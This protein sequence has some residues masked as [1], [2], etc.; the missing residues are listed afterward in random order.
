MKKIAIDIVKIIV[1]STIIA[2]VSCFVIT[3]KAQG[4]NTYMGHS[5]TPKSKEENKRALLR[6]W[7]GFSDCESKKIIDTV[8]FDK[9]YEMLFAGQI[10]VQYHMY[11]STAAGGIVKFKIRI[12][13]TDN[14]VEYRFYDM[15]HK[16]TPG[17]KHK[18]GGP[19]L[20]E[21]PLKGS[22]I[23]GKTWTAYQEQTMAFIHSAENE[24][25]RVVK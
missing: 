11:G 21:K 22:M 9:S 25:V 5:A 3:A 17:V 7:N 2:S 20:E 14:S 15:D 6:W 18:D 13:I 1:V 24:I 16:S 23:F 19:V 8:K 12:E 10:P 4:T